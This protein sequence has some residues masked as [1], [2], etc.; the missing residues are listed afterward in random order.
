MSPFLKS[1]VVATMQTHTK[2]ICLAIGDGANDVNMIQTA[3]VGVGIIGREGRQA[4]NSSDFAIPRFKHLKRL[5]AVHGRLS[6]VRLSGV[7]RYMFY[8]NIV[9]CLPHLWFFCFTNWSPTALY[10]GWLL[11]TY[12]LIW[13]LFPPGEYGF[14]EQDV[15]F[16]S[17]MK[18][19]I[20]YREGRSGRYLDW[21]RFGADVINGI[22][23]SIILFYFNVIMPSNKL[24]DRRGYIDGQIA[25]GMSLFI[26]VV[27][28]VDIQTVI[29]SQHWNV[30]L[31]LGV[32]V[33]ILLFF[34]FNLPYGS[35]PELVPQMYF[36]PQTLFTVAQ[37]YL[38]LLISVVASL[39]PEAVQSF[40][41]GMLRPSF[42]RIIRE[43]E[44][45][46]GGRR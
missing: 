2:R 15:S 31:F 1:R 6:L 36:V 39:V 26:S 32:I 7:I 44:F 29:R 37:H 23:Q 33:S 17:M 22:Y 42:T 13:T 20:V 16:L 21:P 38:M 35:F 24:L 12:N 40:V 25:A 30:F 18:Y 45:M 5:L 9:F 46:E 28:V 11:A 3:N 34:L 19:P 43:S 41:M 4:A 14:F 8:K 10:D 27:L